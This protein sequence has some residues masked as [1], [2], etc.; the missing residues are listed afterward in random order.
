MKLKMVNH[1]NPLSK[2]TKPTWIFLTAGVFSVHRLTL[3]S[4]S[5]LRLLCGVNLESK[6]VRNMF[7]LN[8]AFLAEYF[9]RI[10]SLVSMLG[11]EALTAS[12]VISSRQS[13]RSSML[14][15]S[16]YHKILMP[17]SSRLPTWMTVVFS[18]PGSTSLEILITTH[19]F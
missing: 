15:R 8:S 11:Q 13:F 16:M 7:L 3:C 14:I 19:I 5:I 4:P 1:F 18:A 2:N 9:I 10:V 6:L 12:I 17:P